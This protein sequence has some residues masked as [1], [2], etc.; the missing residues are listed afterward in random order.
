MYLSA[1]YVAFKR[2]AKPLYWELELP[3]GGGEALLQNKR[4]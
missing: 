4:V 1:Y 3:Q 2:Y